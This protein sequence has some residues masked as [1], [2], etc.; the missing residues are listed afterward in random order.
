MMP[1]EN[2]DNRPQDSFDPDLFTDSEA[3]TKRVVTTP[4]EAEGIIQARLR[5]LGMTFQE[6]VASLIAYDC[7][8]EKP[9]LLTGDVCIGNKHSKD[10]RER[11]LRLWREIAAD[12][13]K[14]EKTGSFFSHRVAEAVRKV[15]E[16]L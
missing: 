8:A 13:G 3:R 1:P 2:A 14:P 6:Y 5:A 10:A 15:L 9:H 7:W 16:R 12:F 4:G 11:E